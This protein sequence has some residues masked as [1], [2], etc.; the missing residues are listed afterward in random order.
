[1]KTATYGRGA[2]S[3]TNNQ[4]MY[5]YDLHGVMGFLMLCYAAVPGLNAESFHT[6]CTPLLFRGGGN[7]ALF[8]YSSSRDPVFMITIKIQR[9]F[10]DLLL[11]KIGSPFHWL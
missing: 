9:N 5:Y 1:M 11:G 3:A 2:V 4:L 8:S 10:G 7:P 6:S